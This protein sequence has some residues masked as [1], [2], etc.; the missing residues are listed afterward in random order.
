MQN[1]YWVIISWKLLKP[2]D[3]SFIT[4]TASSIK[5]NTAWC[6]DYYYRSTVL[7]LIFLSEI[8]F[9]YRQV[10]GNIRYI[11]NSIFNLG[12]TLN[13]TWIKFQIQIFPL[14]WK[15][16]TRTVP[17]DELTQFSLDFFGDWGLTVEQMKGNALLQGEIIAKEWNRTEIKK[18]I[19]FSRFRHPILSNMIEI[20]LGGREFYM[21]LKKARSISNGRWWQNEKLH[22]DWVIEE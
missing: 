5:W 1:S 13:Q 6:F 9:L 18:K 10:N 12:I 16:N 3:I 11:F 21:H 19:L 22:V 20:I 15:V 8:Q 2:T 17:I 7:L 4:F 14:N